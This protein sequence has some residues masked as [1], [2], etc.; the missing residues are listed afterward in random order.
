LSPSAD[1]EYFADGMT[2]D[3][4][5]QLSKVASLKVISRTSVMRYKKTEESLRDIA[6]KLGAS[7]LVEGT[8]RRAGNRLR[9][10]T[11]LIE[12]ASDAHL[13]AETYDREMTDVFATQSEVAMRVVDALKAALTH[14]ERARI[15]RRPTE[16]LDAYNAYLLGRFQIARRSADSLENAIVQFRRAVEL[17]PKFAPPYAGLADAY[18]LSSIGYGRAAT[19]SLQTARSAARRAIALDESLAEGHTA[20]GYVQCWF[21]WNLDAAERSFRRAIELNPS[22]AQA[23]QWL[24]QVHIGR[25]NDVAALEAIARARDLDPLSVLVACEAGWPLFFMGDYSR[26]EAHYRRVLTMDSSFGLAHYNLGESLEGL[27]RVADAIDEYERAVT[28]TGGGA[29]AIAKLVRLLVRSGRSDE[30]TRYAGLVQQ[31]ADSGEAIQA[32]L[33]SVLDS[34][35]RIDDAVLAFERAIAAR[36]PAVLMAVIRP[37]AYVVENLQHDSR[38]ASLIG[39]VRPIS[40]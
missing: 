22:H 21:E 35:G 6:P 28:L 39:R 34:L 8:V 26:A 5:A 36:E 20:L 37:A 40:E 16:N 10:V 25:T 33:A 4:I 18:T 31:R 19:N 24:A 1:D 14:D 9:I 30:A 12:A 17:D 15:T 3:I 32:W 38:F 2:E 11:Q 29:F 27:G 23:Y 7:H 13:W